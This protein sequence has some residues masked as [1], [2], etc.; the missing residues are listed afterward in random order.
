MTIFGTSARYLA[1]CEKMNQHPG[2]EHDNE[3]RLGLHCCGHRRAGSPQHTG[4]KGVVLSHT[5][6]CWKCGCDGCVHR[7]CE[8]EDVGGSL[9]GATTDYEKRRLGL[10]EHF[11]DRPADFRFDG[12]RLL[13]IG[14]CLFGVAD[15]GGM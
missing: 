4:C 8:G 5:A 11:D 13:P 12:E 6:L 15:Q 9:C 7:L 1:A 3:V 10:V 14:E 2:A